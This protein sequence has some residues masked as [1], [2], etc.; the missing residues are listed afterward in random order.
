MSAPEATNDRFV[1]EVTLLQQAIESDEEL[2]LL[3][4]EVLGS[5]ALKAESKLK[6]IMGMK[7]NAR[8]KLER[9]SR[10]IAYN[11]ELGQLKESM[12]EGLTGPFSRIALEEL[13]VIDETPFDK[14]DMGQALNNTFTEELFYE[15]VDEEDWE[16]LSE[17]DQITGEW[18]NDLAEHNTLVESCETLETLAKAVYK[19]QQKLGQFFQTRKNITNERLQHVAWEA[20]HVLYAGNDDDTSS[21]VAALAKKGKIADAVA[22]AKNHASS[23]HAKEMMY[24]VVDNEIFGKAIDAVR[25]GHPDMVNGLLKLVTDARTAVSIREAL[26]AYIFEKA[27]KLAQKD[28]PAAERYIRAFASSETARE[29]M[30]I[31]L[32]HTALRYAQNIYLRAPGEAVGYVLDYVAP[33]SCQRQKALELMGISD[34]G[35]PFEFE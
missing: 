20:E 1:E 33:R 18:G 27:A 24:E 30:S 5:V 32:D 13:V 7:K 23:Q 22:Y 4:P 9:A 34:G 3:I 28:L 10:E 16:D 21:L 14:E 2:R 11:Y 31:I 19:R 35:D 17:V 12:P 25:E 29:D 8:K 6:P 26:D 15:V